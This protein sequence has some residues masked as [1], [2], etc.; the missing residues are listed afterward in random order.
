MEDGSRMRFAVELVML[1]QGGKE[2]AGSRKE[3]K[4]KEKAGSESGGGKRRGIGRRRRGAA[5]EKSAK[6]GAARYEAKCEISSHPSIHGMGMDNS[7]GKDLSLRGTS[8]P[9]L[10]DGERQQTS[11]LHP[12]LVPYHGESPQQLSSPGKPQPAPAVVYDV[13]SC[14]SSSEA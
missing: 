13:N 6:C 12:C 2:A 4:G 7:Y 5:G 11:D 14:Q 8:K 3:V 10:K 1:V 9:A